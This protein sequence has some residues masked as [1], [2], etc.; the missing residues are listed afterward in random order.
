MGHTG[1][2]PSPPEQ[3][4]WQEA[5]AEI[6]ASE[7]RSKHFA[8]LNVTCASQGN[9]EA[10][11]DVLEDFAD[12][13]D[14]T[15]ADDWPKGAPYHAT[16][17]YLA[18][19]FRRILAGEDATKALNLNR[20]RGRPSGSAEYDEYEI[21]AMFWFLVRRNVSKFKAKGEI[22]QE[23]GCEEKT[24]DRAADST[25]NLEFPEKFSDEV[26]KH[27]FKRRA[28]AMGKILHR[29]DI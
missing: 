12:A 1:K 22:C 8:E 23:V 17:R 24:V 28:S 20:G 6:R 9:A 11:R 26:L 27:M 14:N 16:A 21:G 25:A 3:D 2:P 10:A 18:D 15:R 4:P 19:C 7:D 5:L 29:L 13:M